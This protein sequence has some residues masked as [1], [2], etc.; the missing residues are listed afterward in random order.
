MPGPW[1]L[2]KYPTVPAKRANVVGETLGIEA[3]EVCSRTMPTDHHLE[4]VGGSN[5]G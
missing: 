4:V 3:I 2:I 5:P 1:Q